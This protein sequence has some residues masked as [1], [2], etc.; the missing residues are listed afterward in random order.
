MDSATQVKERITAWYVFGIGAL[1][2]IIAGAFGSLFYEKGEFLKWLAFNRKPWMD[3]LFY[4]STHLGELI[5]YTIAGI[6]L[7]FVNW[8]KMFVVPIT[9]LVVTVVS[10]IL[11]VLFSHERP[12]V[13]LKRLEWDGPMEVLNYHLIQG[14][15]SFPS[16]HSMAAW[17]LFTYVALCYKKPWISIICLLLALSVSL[18]RVYLLAHFLQDVTA[19]A[20]IGVIIGIV[21]YRLYL[22]LDGMYRKRIEAMPD[23]KAKA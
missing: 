16:G 19:G 11:K 20:A 15:N 13:Y 17:A 21:M 12:S 5:G 6:V 7:W 23:Y 4:Y 10:Y 1:I 2:L 18:S 14:H 9:G 3:Y 22:A 8:R